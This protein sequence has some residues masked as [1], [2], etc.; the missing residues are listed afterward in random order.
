MKGVILQTRIWKV[1]KSYSSCGI[2]VLDNIAIGRKKALGNTQ[3]RGKAFTVNS[4]QTLN[5]YLL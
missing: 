1:W 3:L 2:L 5:W 4:N